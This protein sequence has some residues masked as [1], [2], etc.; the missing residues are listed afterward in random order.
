MFMILQMNLNIWN[1]FILQ[2]GGVGL[3][4]FA[5]AFG[6]KAIFKMLEKK[7]SELKEVN[8]AFIDHLKLTEKELLVIIQKNTDGYEKMARGYEQMANAFNE[9]SQSIDNLSDTIKTKIGRAHV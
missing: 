8:K 9:N 4:I 3:L 5:L 2:L 1:D 7:E 6:I